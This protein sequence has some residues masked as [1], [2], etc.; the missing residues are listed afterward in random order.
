MAIPISTPAPEFIAIDVHDTATQEPRWRPRVLCAL[1]CILYFWLPFNAYRAYHTFPAE[2]HP[3]EPGKA[4]QILSPTG[5]R[6]FNHPEL[7]L[8]TTQFV[9]DWLRTPR[10]TQAIVEIGRQVSAAF[11]ALAVVA[12]ALCGYLANK[13]W[14]FLL[15]GTTTALCPFLIAHS[16]YMKEDAAL[17]LGL[18]L[19]VFASNLF[20]KSTRRRSQLLGAAFLGIAVGLA[21]SAKYFGVIS[22]A[23]ALPA[24]LLKPRGLWSRNRKM[25]VSPIPA[26]CPGLKIHCPIH[27][28]CT[29]RDARVTNEPAANYLALALTGPTDTTPPSA[30]IRF[31]NRR[32]VHIPAPL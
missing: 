21:M 12:F 22:L 4:A 8:E 29:G 27:I 16:R 11:A 23:L 26:M 3:D 5:E 13:L 2:W 7:L 31:R 1:L 30:L 18:A 32:S 28:A 24:L 25:G 10:D 17:I 9:T 14:G 20:W 6:N 19:V 15:T